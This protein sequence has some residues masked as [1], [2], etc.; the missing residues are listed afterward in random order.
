MNHRPSAAAEDT[1][2]L[3]ADAQPSHPGEPSD[4]RHDSRKRPQP[5]AN[6][7]WMVTKEHYDWM[8]THAPFSSSVQTS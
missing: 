7:A 8:D 6:W 2:H 1:L 4:V 3:A 5:R